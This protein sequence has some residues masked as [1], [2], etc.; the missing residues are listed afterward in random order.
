MEIPLLRPIGDH[1][2][3]APRAGSGT[4][5]PLCPCAKTYRRA[6]RTT[7]TREE[8][9]LTAGTSASSCPS[10]TTLKMRPVF[11]GMWIRILYSWSTT[12]LC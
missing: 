7:R 2:E 5:A 12:S 10:L 4:D 9:A 11:G 3:D 1:S 6:L 8:R